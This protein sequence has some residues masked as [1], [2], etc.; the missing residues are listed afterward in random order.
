MA[1][2]AP[3]TP[4]PTHRITLDADGLPLSALLALP[5]HRPPRAVVVAV[6]GGGMRAG[7][8]DSR[9]RP[10]HSLLTLGAELGYTVLAVDRPGYGASAAHLPQGQSLADQAATLHAALAGFA[11]TREQ[12]AGHFVVAHSNGGKLALALAAGHEPGTGTGLVGLDISGLGT[13]PAVEPH[14]LPGPGRPG[15]WRRH[16]GPLRLYPPEAF[17]QCR[18]VVAPVPARE[19]REAARW[20][21]MYP[22]IAARVSVPVRFT[23]AEQEQWW[24]Q[25]EQALSALRAPLAAPHVVIDRQPDAGHNISL[26]WASRTYHLK[27]LAFLEQCLL[28]RETAAPTAPRTPC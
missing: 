25:D 12:G 9:A 20:P 28:A 17:G 15:T 24:H 26:G 6:H 19:A 13:R 21:Q 27:A 11:R 4:P 8:F 1:E 5:E 23:F 3:R 18:G 10:G 2:P 16:W 14:D 22:A 7:Y